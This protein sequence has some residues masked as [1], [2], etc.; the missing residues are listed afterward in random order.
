MIQTTIA[1][2]N[3]NFAFLLIEIKK[4]LNLCSRN[5]Y[6]YILPKHELHVVPSPRATDINHSRSSISGSV[7]PKDPKDLPQHS[8][9]ETKRRSGCLQ[10]PPSIRCSQH[11]PAVKNLLFCLT[12]TKLTLQL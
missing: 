1:K 3:V 8:V 2:A 10:L 5:I 11:V 6:I 4:I 9:R 7:N 12:H